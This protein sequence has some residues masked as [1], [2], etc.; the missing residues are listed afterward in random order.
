MNKEYELNS[1]A[2]SDEIRGDYMVYEIKYANG[3]KEYVSREVFRKLKALK[4]IKKK[5]VNVSLFNNLRSRTMY[6]EWVDDKTRNLT[7]TE[8]DLLKEVLK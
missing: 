1:Y 2:K 6:N 4:I 5:R 7:E 8:F 3:W